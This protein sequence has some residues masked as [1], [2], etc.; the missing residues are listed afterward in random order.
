M[1]TLVRQ[2]RLSDF[3]ADQIDALTYGRGMDTTRFTP[4]PA[5]RRRY[6]SRAALEEFAAAAARGLL[7]AERV[8]ATLGSIAA[9]VGSAGARRG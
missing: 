3:S 6:S 2:A 9:V 7:S 1:A 5:S 4:S 8:E